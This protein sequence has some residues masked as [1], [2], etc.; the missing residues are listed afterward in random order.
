MLAL[1]LMLASLAAPSTVRAQE[2]PGA[3]DAFVRV[4][5]A[6]FVL[7]G[8]PWHFL[9]ANVAVMH[10]PVHRGAMERTLDAVRDDGLSVVR[11]WA[12]GERPDGSPAWARDYAF[13]VGEEGWVD[14][15]FEHLDRVLAAASERGL[16]VIVVLAN[17]W[18]D[19]GGIPRYL[20][21]AGALPESAQPRELT[22]LEVA[23]F[24]D[25]SR[26]DVLYR[27]HVARVVNHVNGVTG[28]A[29]RD[30][31]TILGWELANELGAYPRDR[32]ALV[33]WVTES[34]R[35]VRSLDA[36]HL[37]SAGHI[38]YQR[39]SDRRTWLA[40]QRIAEIDYADAHAYPLQSG[41][42]QTLAELGRYV[43]DRVQLAHH[44]AHKPFVWGEYG[45]STR[46]R[47]LFGLR[48][49]AWLDGFLARSQR[50]GVDG[51][52][53][54][55]YA[56]H[57]A[58]AAEHAI[59]PDGDGVAETLDVRRTL[60]RQARRWRTTPPAE[61]N[62]RLGE[63]RGEE[64]LAPLERELRG[65]QTPHT[66]WHPTVDG[67][68]TLA[69]APRTFA[70]ARFESGGIWREPP[71]AHV[72]G[73]GGGEVVYRFRPPTGQRVPAR[74]VVRF[75][76]SS[77]LPGAG[78]GSRPTDVSRVH[79]LLGDVEVGVLVAPVDDGHGAWV[80]LA[81]DDAAVLARAFAPHSR[82]SELRL[83]VEPDQSGGGLCL[84][85]ED[86]EHP[87]SPVGRIELVWQSPDP[88]APAR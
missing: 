47:T 8:E 38:G 1:L 17:R 64:P 22:E 70:R 27:A 45:F 39:A 50:D 9:G 86:F 80:E 67:A 71:V 76:A 15:S 35:F 19:Y 82:V 25:C 14:S 5:G 12:L 81:V 87:E 57:E 61:R 2:P 37:I 24:Y 20:R 69:I 59:Y 51:A 7:R 74:L 36:R 13:R 75:R 40:V 41:G 79:V 88:E 48:R 43:D 6:G 62:A 21:W 4:Q 68:H 72:W 49:T 34:A 84:Y 73:A 44:V 31:P 11:V 26:C 85:E 42:V 53:I 66:D 78:G 3:A 65:S 10:G 33:R 54:W 29:Y 16:R 46:Q 56:P 52:L 32:D 23:A 83:R 58:R 18:S 55:H 60:A 77:E 63:A 28:V 30:D